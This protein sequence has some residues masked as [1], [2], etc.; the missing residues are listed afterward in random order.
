[1]KRR[2]TRKKQQELIKEQKN[3][4]TDM[5]VGIVVSVLFIMLLL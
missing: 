2:T 3:Y 4:L 5:I 1:M